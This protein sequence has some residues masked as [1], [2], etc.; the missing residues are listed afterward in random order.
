MKP[1]IIFLMADDLGYGDLGCYDA[2]KIPTPNIDRIAREGL[3][4]TDAHASSALCTPSRY[5]ILTGR[6]SWRSRLK[7]GVLWGFSPPLIEPDRPTVARLLQQH[8]Y[9]T[10][11]IGKWHLGLNWT[12]IDGS[13]PD[14]KGN[15]RIINYTAPLTGGAQSLGFDYS[16]NISGSLDMAPYCF[17][18][19]G[20]VV[21]LP[22]VEKEPYNPQQRPGLMPPTWRDEEVDITFAQKAVAW[23][24]KRTE[25]D[26]PFFLYLTPSAPH[27]PCMPPDFIMGRSS[28]GQR[29]DMIT[30]FDWI[31]G[32]IDEVLRRHN[33]T[34]N[35][36]LIITS[37]N[38]A[39]TTD[40]YGNS[41][42]HKANGDLRGQKADIWD[43]GH[44]EP[45][46]IRWP[47]EVAAGH[48]SNQLICLGDLMATCSAVI[49]AELPDGAG[50]DSSNILPIMKGWDEPVRD[51]L[52]H[53]SGDGMFSIRRGPW[54]LIEGLGS[55]GFTKPARVESQPDGPAGQLYNIAEDLGEQNNL[56]QEQP[57][58]V[59]QLS[60]LLAEIV[61]SPN[62]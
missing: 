21:D 57:K 2:T 50:P 29:G 28:A 48:I 18:E 26:R 32:Q 31:V 60:K 19:N 37:D 42:G 55:G 38:G 8:G 7:R 44:R 11:S 10:A 40:Y 53:H 3:R 35:T 41:W 30:L 51:T 9:A 54:K 59:A 12:T 27:R 34:D 36:L 25:E 5:S 52:V 61:A 47:G 62:S 43:G 33:L 22:T 39:Q 20:R 17:I 46:I 24:E 15:G 13:E 14:P 56:W 49:G 16:F 1:N 45:F 23:I 4:F 6:Y 58:V